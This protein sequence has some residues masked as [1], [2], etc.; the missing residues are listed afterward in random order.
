M[1]AKDKQAF[2][3][4]WAHNP[5]QGQAILDF[6]KKYRKTNNSFKSAMKEIKQL[7]KKGK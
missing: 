4:L 7:Q 2:L 3:K 1:K 6:G 5:E